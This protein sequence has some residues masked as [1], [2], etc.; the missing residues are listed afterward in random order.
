MTVKLLPT[1]DAPST[2]ALLLFRFTALAP[3]LLKDTAPVNELSC[4]KV[5]GLVPAVKLEVPGTVNAPV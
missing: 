5:I 2:V 4:V 1:V 3:L